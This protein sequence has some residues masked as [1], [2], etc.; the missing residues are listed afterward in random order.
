M[1]KLSL[2]I[3]TL[4]IIASDLTAG[5]SPSV[6]IA[7]DPNPER[8]VAGYIFYERLGHRYS[9]LDVIERSR[10]PSY[11]LQAISRGKHYYSVTAY[12]NNG[13]ESDHSDELILV[14]D[15]TSH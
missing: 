3:F 6:T 15:G 12:T 8:N 5:R 14:W 4:L 13:V 7:W 9:A 10:E 2:I 1:K 11:T